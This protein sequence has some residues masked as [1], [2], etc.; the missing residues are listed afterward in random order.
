[1]PR[2]I[3]S[4][5]IGLHSTHRLPQ[6]SGE[7]HAMLH[8]ESVR[9]GG[10]GDEDLPRSDVRMKCF[11]GRMNRLARRIHE[12]GFRKAH[13]YVLIGGGCQPVKR[14]AR[15]PCWELGWMRLPRTSNSQGQ[16]ER[17]PQR[18]G[19]VNGV[20]FGKQALHIDCQWLLPT[21]VG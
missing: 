9:G 12:N 13:V 21:L 15:G 11:S 16:H 10:G 17:K 5:R 2:W 3:E 1:M 18:R 20:R 14:V 8:Y 6:R 4:G 19:Q 7:Q